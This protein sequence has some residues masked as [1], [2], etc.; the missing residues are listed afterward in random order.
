[1]KFQLLIKC[2][3]LKNK[4]LKPSVV[5]FILLI[6]VKMPTIYF[7]GHF[8]IYEQDKFHA[9]GLDAQVNL[10]LLSCAGCFLSIR[11]ILFIKMGIV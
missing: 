4:R 8:N 6:N 5:V 9:S 11:G 10:S 3:K 1:M 7:C 2:K